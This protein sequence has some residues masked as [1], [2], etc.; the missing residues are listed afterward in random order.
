MTVVIQM[1]VRRLSL[2][3]LLGRIRDRSP[4][5][6]AAVAGGA[7]A[8]GLGLG[9]FAALVMMLW[10][11]SPYPDSGPG[12][13]LHVA[14]G[15][16]LLAHGAELVRTDTLSG[17]SAPVGVTPLLLFVLPVWLVHRAARDAMA[18]GD[19]DGDDGDPG[20]H[21]GVQVSAPTAWAGVVLGYLAV[22]SG[23]ALYAA[24]GVLRPSWA[25]TGVCVPAVAVLAAGAGVW[26]ACGRPR[27]PVA[28]DGALPRRMRRILFGDLGDLGGGVGDDGRDWLGTALRAAGAGAAV[29]V[30]G[31]ALLVAV[32]SVWHSDIA[33][34]AFLQLTEGWSGRFAVL[35]LCVALVPNAAVWGAAYALGPG[36]VLGSGHVVAPLSSDPAPLLPPFP[37]LAAV[38]EP[39]AGTWVNWAAGTVPVLAGVT[40]GVFVARAAGGGVEGAG[41]SRRRTAG[42]AVV[43]G[44]VCGVVLGGLA[45]LAG[46]PLGVGALARFGPVWWQVGGA[47]TAWVV[48]VGVPVAVWARGWRSR[49]RGPVGP[50]GF[51]R[52]EAAVVAAV[53][54]LE[55]VAGA[56]AGAGGAAA[57]EQVEVY[58]DEGDGFGYEP[59]DFAAVEAGEGLEAME[60]PVWLGDAA[61][62]IR[63]AALREV[64]EELPREG[65]GDLE[66]HGHGQ[67][68]GEGQGPGQGE[69]QRQGQRQ[70]QDQGQDQ[71]QGGA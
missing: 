11:S 29:L 65:E 68:P 56:G 59:Y 15:L 16:W 21:G 7:L 63:W 2:S 54:A 6:A 19:D 24:G 12:G 28:A 67:G 47:V 69:G 10:I 64:G 31:G 22:G 45:V 27:G 52:R 30:G 60:G 57:V 37:L 33:R 62:E 50:V 35:L 66:G 3:P 42:G 9:S 25:W 70:G 20:D 23:A 17:V 26:T 61:R 36:Y 18:E 51:W 44:A 58:D 14:A 40:V 53:A 39:G 49:R 4:G 48:G 34:G 46:G 38:P 32:S 71:G 43:A 5:L 41:W 55:G 8:A 1:T 13:A